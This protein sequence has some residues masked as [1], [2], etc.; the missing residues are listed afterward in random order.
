[1]RKDTIQKVL[2]ILVAVMVMPMAVMIMLRQAAPY[3]VLDS[4]Q[5]SP[6]VQ[7]HLLVLAMIEKESGNGTRLYNPDEE[8]YGVLQIRRGALLDVNEYAGTNYTLQ[9]MYSS[10]ALSA[11]ALYQYCKRYHASTPEWMARLWAGGPKGRYSDAAG[12]YWLDIQ[13]RMERIQKEKSN[14]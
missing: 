3:P 12:R 4:K 13:K 9:D 11:W 10:Q 5:L 7:R 1:M 8:A 6:G 14:H 2:W